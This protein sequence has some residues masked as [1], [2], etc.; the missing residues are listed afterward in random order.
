[1]RSEFVEINDQNIGVFFV[2]YGSVFNEAPW[3]DGW[4][5]DVSMST[6]FDGPLIKIHDGRLA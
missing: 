2:L 1:M 4:H 6:L 3:N 5:E